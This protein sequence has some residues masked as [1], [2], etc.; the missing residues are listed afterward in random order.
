MYF[1]S[2]ISEKFIGFRWK[3]HTNALINDI[4]IRSKGACEKEEIIDD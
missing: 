2:K 1:F 4:L 3:C